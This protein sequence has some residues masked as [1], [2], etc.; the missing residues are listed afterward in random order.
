MARCVH[1]VDVKIFT[2]EVDVFEMT[3][4]KMKNMGR[5]WNKK[6]NLI[7]YLPGR[8][9]LTWPANQLKLSHYLWEIRL[10]LSQIKSNSKVGIKL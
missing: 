6:V 1:L 10:D 9:E 2:F 3:K 8:G 4:A 7:L 5:V